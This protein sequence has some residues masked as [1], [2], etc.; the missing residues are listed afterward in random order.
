[1]LK[2]YLQQIRQG[3]AV[4]YGRMLELLPADFVRR[5]SELFKVRQLGNGRWQVSIL[6]E[7]LFAELE[8]YAAFPHSRRE[9]ALLGNSHQMS[10]GVV[11]QLVYHTAGQQ[12]QPEAVVLTSQQSWQQYQP[13]A[14]L[15]L[16]E[17]ESCF[18]RYRELLPVIT[19]MLV[20]PL[21]LSQCDV[22][23]SAGSKASSALLAQ[24]YQQYQRIYCAFDFDAAGLELFDLLHQRYGDKVRFVAPADCTP[25]LPLFVCKV[26]QATHMVKALALAEKHQLYGLLQA[27][28]QK[29]HFMEQEALLTSIPAPL[30]D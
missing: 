6:S 10:T 19:Q 2:K 30:S 7:P 28:Q 15:V 23:F 22:G 9:A 8:H 29:D 17:N 1:M 21:D 5:K 16:V 26:K 24:F 13:K 12:Q 25:W 20:L 11:Y 18:F 3:K 14:N 27:L 4:H